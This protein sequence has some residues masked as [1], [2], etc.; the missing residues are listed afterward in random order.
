MYFFSKRLHLVISL[1]IDAQESMSDA[2]CADL[3]NVVREAP[4]TG[5]CTKGV[6]P[7]LDRKKFLNTHHHSAIQKECESKLRRMVIRRLQLFHDPTIH[8]IDVRMEMENITFLN[9]VWIDLRSLSL[10]TGL[11]G[12]RS[13]I[14]CEPSV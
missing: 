8:Q 7:E 5:L 1:S 14:Q 6:L 13:K 12:L 2:T 10:L 3:H 11:E 9:L 4:M